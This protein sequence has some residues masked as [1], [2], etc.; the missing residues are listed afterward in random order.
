MSKI[1]RWRVD[2]SDVRHSIPVG[3]TV[4]FD[5]EQGS[6]RVKFGDKGIVIEKCETLFCDSEAESE[7]LEY[8]K[9]TQDEHTERMKTEAEC[10]LR[11]DKFRGVY[12]F[13]GGDRRGPIWNAGR[14][15]G[16]H[17]GYSLVRRIELIEEKLGLRSE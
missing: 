7:A 6:V 11:S 9:M 15:P 4:I 2:G 1:I 14:N 13:K 8:G 17:S 10:F 12:P 3:A 5:A 16:H